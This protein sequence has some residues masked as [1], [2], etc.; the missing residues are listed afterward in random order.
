MDDD[1]FVQ[2]IESCTLPPESF[3]HR[4]HIRLAWIYL[5]T[6]NFVA[7]C[8]RLRASVLRFS[9][10]HGAAGK[11]HA[12]VTLAWMYLLKEASGKHTSADSFDQF[13]N[14][15]P[16]L[17]TIRTLELYYSPETLAS[18]EAR[19]RWIAP[20]RRPLRLWP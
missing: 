9:M 4:D 13:L 14:A 16:E 2:Q 20:D 12:T 5:R 10:H 11:Y 1:S 7:A 17:L 6:M 18:H 3:H 19:E 15:H 8:E